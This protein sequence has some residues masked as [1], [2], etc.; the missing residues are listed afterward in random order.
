M[1]DRKRASTKAAAKQRGL[2]ISRH[3]T[4]AGESPYTSVEWSRRTS[5]ITNP[6]GSVVFE[7]KD[8][9]IPA[10]WSQ[11]AAD[12]MV[13]KYFRKAGVPQYDEQG[14][15]LLNEDGSPVLGPE[16]SAR[17]V[18][19]RLAGCWTH[20][21]K[22]HGYF[23]TAADAEAFYDELAYMLLHQMAA[24]NSPQWFNTGLN[25]AYGITGP[26]QG[27]YYTDPVTGEVKESEDAYTHPQPHA[28]QPYHALVS[29]PGGPMAI[30]EIVEKNLVGHPG[31]RGQGERPEAG[32]PDCAEERRDGRGDAGSP[33]A[34]SR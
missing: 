11:V 2:T 22:E 20:W 6:D 24:P 26:A 34:G 8:A 32:L 25:W 5:R 19:D 4:K 27:H 12:I 29:T 15:P 31:R 3:F 17:Q 28:C 7:M 13:S 23:A 9:E 33:G 21:G 1:S 10:S 16:R 18:I 30:G 14:Q